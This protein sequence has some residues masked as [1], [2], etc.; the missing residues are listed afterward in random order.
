[1]TSTPTQAHPLPL[2]RGSD[3]GLLPQQRGILTPEQ[4]RLGAETAKTNREAALKGQI[5]QTEV[6]LEYT[7][8]PAIGSTGGVA[9]VGWELHGYDHPWYLASKELCLQAIP[10]H[11]S[12][13]GR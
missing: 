1:M 13:Y 8:R 7:L 6:H 12:I 4:R 5:D 9:N 3:T 10:G 11:R 2:D